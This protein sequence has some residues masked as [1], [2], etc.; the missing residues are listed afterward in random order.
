MED[1]AHLHAKNLSLLFDDIT[2]TSL[3]SHIMT[4]EI[5]TNSAYF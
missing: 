2:L 1:N 3:Q 4:F 5:V